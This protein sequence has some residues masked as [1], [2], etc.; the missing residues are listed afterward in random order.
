MEED[1]YEIKSDE[2]NGFYTWSME[3]LIDEANAAGSFYNPP[4]LNH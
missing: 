1:I 4:Y 3:P 2:S